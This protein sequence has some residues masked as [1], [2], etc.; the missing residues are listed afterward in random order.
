MALRTTH[1]IAKWLRSIPKNIEKTHLST[2]SYCWKFSESG[3]RRQRR[4]RLKAAE[5]AEVNVQEM[6]REIHAAADD[7]DADIAPGNLWEIYGK[8]MGNLWWFMGE[9]PSGV[10]KHGENP[11]WIEVLFQENHWEMV[12]GFQHT[13]FD[14]TGGYWG[15]WRVFGEFFCETFWRFQSDLSVIL[16]QT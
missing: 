7:V 11:P 1:I 15:I 10:V 9:K 14:E 16:S 5:A 2:A 12:H 6:R 13:M 8:S 4:Q 3:S